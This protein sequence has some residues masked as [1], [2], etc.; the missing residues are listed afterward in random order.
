MIICINLFHCISV[1]QKSKIRQSSYRE[2]ML[3]TKLGI[4]VRKYVKTK[5]ILKS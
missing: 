4:M 1:V 3:I 2:G 5:H